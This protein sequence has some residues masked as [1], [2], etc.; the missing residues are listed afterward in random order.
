M[1]DSAVNIAKHTDLMQ[2]ETISMPGGL[3]NVEKIV[4]DPHAPEA[5]A[6]G[7]N[8][9]MTVYLKRIDT[10][11]L[12][13][14][15]RSYLGRH[16]HT[17][18]D[19]PVFA[20][21]DLMIEPATGHFYAYDAASDKLRF[22]NSSK[23]Y[24]LGTDL[25]TDPSVPAVWR[26]PYTSPKAKRGML[27]AQNH[28]RLEGHPIKSR[29]NDAVR[30][31]HHEEDMRKGGY[32][33]PDNPVRLNNEAALATTRTAANRAI[34]HLQSMK[35]DQPIPALQDDGHREAFLGE[36][37]TRLLSSAARQ[38]IT[39][40][41]VGADGQPRLD[42]DG[43]PRELA[44]LG[45][46]WDGVDMQY[47][48]KR[49][50]KLI[51]VGPNGYYIMETVQS[52]PVCAA[53]GISG[54]GLTPGNLLHAMM[55]SP[56]QQYTK[57]LYRLGHAGVELIDPPKAGESD[58]AALLLDKLQHYVD[59]ADTTLLSWLSTQAGGPAYPPRAVFDTV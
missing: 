36:L 10:Y 42:A 39:L 2:A 33:E 56:G 52:K 20:D 58:N 16:T 21:G 12:E 55:A 17:G 35:A 51:G 18:D 26:Y 41:E 4:N 14:R 7:D 40:V 9:G 29:L 15:M 24:F 44:R 50:A 46:S 37:L 22:A 30:N 1:Q 8:Q 38:A 53:V 59:D 25:D 32:Y 28:A 19:R 57:P 31:V 34:A 47:D 54:A 45:T 23:N 11:A 27:D 13:Q 48:V 49:P 43:Q 6:A 5:D 3:F